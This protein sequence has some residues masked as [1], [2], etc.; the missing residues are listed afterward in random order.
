MFLRLF[1]SRDSR[2]AL[3]SKLFL[4]SWYGDLVDNLDV[5]GAIDCFGGDKKSGAF[6]IKRWVIAYLFIF[7]NIISEIL[8]CFYPH[9]KSE[10]NY[11]FLALIKFIILFPNWSNQI[12]LN[13]LYILQ[14]IYQFH[15]TVF[16]KSQS[17]FCFL[18]ELMS[19]WPQIL[20]LYFWWLAN[21]LFIW[22]QR[23][24]DF[25]N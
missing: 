21:Q 3:P 6:S 9:L 5:Y 25:L 19:L 12:Q 8:W 17:S 15:Q 18:L 20:L 1:D 24:I 23:C 11:F 2:E 4:A 13:F 7:L 10:F 22:K 16:V 14:P